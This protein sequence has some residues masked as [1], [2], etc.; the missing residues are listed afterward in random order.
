MISVETDYKCAFSKIGF[1]AIIS[2][3]ASA[4][5][6]K[7]PMKTVQVAFVDGDSLQIYNT[8]GRLHDMNRSGMIIYIITLLSKDLNRTSIP[9]CFSDAI[10]DKKISV[11]EL[12]K[13]VQ[14]VVNTTPKSLIGHRH[15]EALHRV[16]STS[17]KEQL[18]LKLLAEGITP[19]DISHQL[20][21]SVKAIS[22]YKNEAAKRHGVR[23]FNELY[24]LKRHSKSL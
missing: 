17:K 11:D 5:L 13:Q 24:M 23:N 14:S 7:Y 19:K 3:V 6:S 8:I 12:I 9:R 15:P 22:R 4:G 21:L 1:D 2:S 18:V 10:V 16:L 20:N